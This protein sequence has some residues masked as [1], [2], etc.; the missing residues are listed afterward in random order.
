MAATPGGCGQLGASHGVKKGWAGVCLL[1]CS[2][3][4]GRKRWKQDYKWWS[5]SPGSHRSQ[6]DPNRIQVT[7][8]P[9]T[10]VEPGRASTT[11]AGEENRDCIS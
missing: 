7:G 4:L 1:A 6:G 8:G 9:S 11:S 5:W 3:V 2:L 10:S